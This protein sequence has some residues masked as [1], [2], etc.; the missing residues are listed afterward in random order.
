MSIRGAALS[1]LLLVCSADA[2]TGQPAGATLPPPAQHLGVRTCAGAPCHGNEAVV[3]RVVRQN[4]YATWSR[5]DAHSRAYQVLLDEPARRIAAKL[6]LARPPHESDLC[7]DCHADNVPVSQRGTQFALEDGVGCEACHGG[8]ERWL[9][10][11]I[12]GSGDHR[13]FVEL[14]LLPTDDATARAERCLSCHYGTETKFV[15]HRLYGAGHPRLRFELDTFTATQP[16]HFQIDEDYEKRHKQVGNAARTWAIGQAVAARSS[17]AALAD[18]RRKDGIWPEFTHF[19][20]YACHHAMSELRWSPRPSM[21]VAARPGVARLN[22]AS[23]VLL[24]HALD[25]LEPALAGR[26]RAETRALHGAFSA[27]TDDAT[28]AVSD[29]RS[30]LDLALRSVEAWQPSPE[31]VRAVALSVI[32]AGVS[33]AGRDYLTAEQVAM[34]VQALAQG[35]AQLGVLGD[36]TLRAIDVESAQLLEATRD[37]ERFEPARAAAA[38]RRLRLRLASERDATGG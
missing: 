4:E 32:D 9:G 15:R 20:C 26:L 13:R 27:G 3:G 28:R 5:H 14:G 24:V 18:G 6:G 19:D 1:L 30:T 11:H 36:A 34:A 33:E 21:G 7:L 10:P 16:A 12:S 38:L 8:A 35:L 22:D 23:L 31:P 37:P 29:L 25:V 2:G 17:L